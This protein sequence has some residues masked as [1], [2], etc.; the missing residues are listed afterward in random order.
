MN[1]TKRGEKRE[2]GGG[3]WNQKGGGGGQGNRSSKIY[4]LGQ[5]EIFNCVQELA[6]QKNIYV[7]T[8]YHMSIYD[9]KIP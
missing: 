3:R 5:R 2:D 8:D 7:R 4:L 6:I 1:E 9:N